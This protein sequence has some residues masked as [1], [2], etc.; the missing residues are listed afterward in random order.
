MTNFIWTEI[1]G[2]PKIGIPSIKSFIHHHPTLFVHV[3][4][5]EE[6]L[7]E[8]RSF[9]QV[10]PMYLTASFMESLLYF[11]SRFTRNSS[12]LS[13]SILRNGFKKGHLGTAMLWEYVIRNIN[14][15]I[16]IHFDSDVI[17]LGKC[18]ENLTSSVKKGGLAGPIRNY[19]NN[20]HGRS[21]LQH[22]NDLCQT[23]LFGFEQKY[24]P[25]HLGYILQAHCKGKF[26]LDKRP[27][28]DFF[29]PI[30]MQMIDNGAKPQFLD[31]DD[32]G[33]C[34]FSGN[35]KNKFQAFND[36]ETEYKIDVGEKLIHFS[37]VGSGYN[38]Y[39]NGASIGSTEYSKYALDRFALFNYVIYGEEIGVN[40]SAYQR[41][42]DFLETREVRKFAA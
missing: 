40:L 6:D 42:I 37:A 4:G 25:K 41:L 8:L 9:P 20:P 24:L 15:D 28:L 12:S 10:V 3:F 7:D 35:R 30:M 1:F 26:L 31:P 21:E 32:F 22:M 14:S 5:F 13:P 17:F 38:I 27:V 36:F 16:F 33:G 29:D 34:N 18:I 39:R 23:Y 11:I 19:R 2:C